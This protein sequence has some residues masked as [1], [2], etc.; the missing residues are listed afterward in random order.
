[1]TLSREHLD[2]L[3]ASGISPDYAAVRGYETIT[4]TT[5]LADLGI[6]KAGRSTPGLLVPQLRAD[7]STWGYQYRPDTPRL[8]GG[9]PVKYETPTGQRNGLD[10]PPGVAAMLGD[11]TVPLWITEGVKKADCGAIHGLC[12]VAL[13]GVWNWI[14][15]STAGGKMALPEW[16]DIALNDRRVVIA[17][18]GDV[19]RKPPV[20]KAAGALA[21]YLATKGAH[22]EYLWL[23]DTDDKTGLDDYLAEHPA[24]SLWALVKP[25]MPP[26]SPPRAA[27]PPGPAA[28]APEPVTPV[29]IDHAHN[30]FRRWLGQDYDTA[31]LDVMLAAVAA[32]R[33]DGDPLWL[34]VVSGPGNAK[35]ETVQACDGVGAIVVSSIASEAALLSA[36]PER[37]RSATATGGLLRRIGGRGVLVVKDVTTVLSMNRDTRASVLAALREVYDGRW[38][39]E[40]G[41]DGGKSIAWNGRIAVIGAVTTAW[42]TAHAVIATM[43]DR[44]VLVRMDSTRGRQA[45]GRRAIGN[46]GS[47]ITMR[48]ELAAAVGGVIAGMDTHPTTLSEEETETL[49]AAAD[50]VTL[51]RTGVEYD[52]RGDVIDAHAPEMPTR[53][54]KQL[55][56][57][58]RGGVAI[59]M[60]RTAALRLA[61]RCARDSMPPLRLAIIEDLAAHPHSSTAEV[62]KRLDR[63]RT[64]VDRQLQALHML[65]V[66]T[67]DEVAYDDNG[68]SRWFYDI[69]AGIDPEVLTPP[70]VDTE[71]ESSPEMSLT[72]PNP[73]EREVSE[74]DCQTAASQLP[75]DKTGALPAREA[76]HDAYRNGLCRDGCGRQ[77]SPGRPRCETC[78]RTHQAVM[79]GYD[80]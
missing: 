77:H 50:L 27:A 54:A 30:M 62:R 14:T 15:T 31:A 11:P 7:G 71:D 42:D 79:A 69:A 9:K 60:D 75:T 22:I 51:V 1:M 3:A 32:E 39:R 21:A 67:V 28:P 10:V 19:A 25:T 76:T 45:A 78:H 41:T 72:T 38:T 4:A 57:V 33:L 35:T 46:T 70:E 63:P 23:P 20:R 13:S 56:Q 6:T 12:I 65:G 26:P 53:F 24:E 36:T 47:E 16:R 52:Y 74:S 73:H 43:G 61:I 2:A 55:A 68:R 18:D 44:F 34:L 48:A 29:G 37:E 80:H 49:L 5:R 59:G 66:L 8:R 17:F 40:V 64:T 58:V